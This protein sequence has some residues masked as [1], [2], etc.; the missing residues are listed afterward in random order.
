MTMNAARPQSNAWR[1]ENGKE[2]KQQRE[3]GKPG[4]RQRHREIERKNNIERARP[5]VGVGACAQLPPRGDLRRETETQRDREKKQDRESE[6]T[7]GG[8][9]LCPTASTWGG[10]P[11]LGCVVLS[12]LVLA[13]VKVGSRVLS[14]T[15]LLCLR[16][17][18]KTKG[19]GHNFLDGVCLLVGIS[20]ESKAVRFFVGLCA[21]NYPIGWTMA[22]GPRQPDRRDN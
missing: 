17:C 3:R 15:L 22:A 8:G 7:S 2:R 14:D 10:T 16:I 19:L 5:K 1:E 11:Q 12:L 4:G 20:K 13:S 9:S 18:S 21:F 6:S